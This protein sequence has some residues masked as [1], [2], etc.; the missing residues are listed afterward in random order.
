MTSPTSAEPHQPLAG[1]GLIVFGVLM[2]AIS[3]AITKSLVGAYSVP[4][5]VFVKTIPALIVMMPWFLSRK[6]IG[7]MKSKRPVALFFRSLLG[8]AEMACFFIA[9]RTVP[10]ADATALYYA[11][12]LIATAL[13]VPLLGEQVGWRRW[14]AIG[15]GFLGMLLIVKPEATGMS[16]GVMFVLIGTGLY[17]LLMVANRYL[18]RTET[19][20]AMVVYAFIL[21]AVVMGVLTPFYWV[22]MPLNDFL[23]MAALGLISTLGVFAFV[24]AYVIAPVS[25]IAP[26]DYTALIW[27]VLFGYVFWNEVPELEVWMGAGLILLC[28]L[29]VLH[30]E[31]V[32]GHDQ[33]AKSHALDHK[34]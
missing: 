13:S 12:P 11:A 20:T 19:T 10:L 21:E 24:R 4:Q 28:G 5:I 31:H 26:F 23:I 17:A 8:L 27:A 18:G 2:F 16:M 29:Y 25:T 30:R 15:A 9:L 33:D 1:I 6:R 14:I 32:T 3:D 34:D 7:R 22:P